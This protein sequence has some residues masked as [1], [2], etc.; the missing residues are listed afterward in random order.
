MVQMSKL[1]VKMKQIFCSIQY[2]LIYNP[3]SSLIQYI[4]RWNRLLLI[5]HKDLLRHLYFLL[6]GRN[7]DIYIRNNK[8]KKKEKQ[9]TWTS[10]SANISR[11]ASDRILP[12]NMW[13]DLP[14]TVTP[15]YEITFVLQVLSFHHSVIVI[16]PSISPLK[17]KRILN[18]HSII[19]NNHPI[20]FNN[21]I[22]TK[23]TG[24]VLISYRDNL[25]LLWQFLMHFKSTRGC[26]V[27]NIAIQDFQ[28]NGFNQQRDARNKWEVQREF[29]VL[30][31]QILRN[32]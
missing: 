19:F 22:W 16:I 30:R 4:Q 14:L 26:S 29:I 7:F 15:Y 11:N 9:A 1:I 32:F 21:I 27:S 6:I 20:I 12:F 13:V 17:K 23:F 25:F 8:K 31:K 3:L 18:N 2:D 24:I 28:Y 5:L 10:I